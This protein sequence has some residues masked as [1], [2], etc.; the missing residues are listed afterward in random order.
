MILPPHA[1]LLPAS[2]CRIQSLPSGLADVG[3]AGQPLPSHDLQEARGTPSA[4][5]LVA[6]ATGSVLISKLLI[7]GVYLLN[8]AVVC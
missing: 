2:L 5:Q 3:P 7:V 1:S 8:V 6:S 4:G